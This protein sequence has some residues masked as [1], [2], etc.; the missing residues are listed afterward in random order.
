LPVLVL[1]FVAT[2]VAVVLIVAAVVGLAP[3]RTVAVGPGFDGRILVGLPSGGG[4]T[5]HL[6]GDGAEVDGGPLTHV[7]RARCPVLL[8]TADGIAVR[9]RWKGIRFESF[10]G[11]IGS[12]WYSTMYNGGERWSTDLSTLAMIDFDRGPSVITF[13]DGDLERP[14]V[15]AYAVPGSFE[16]ILSTDGA[17]L[18]LA[19]PDG[20]GSL[21]IHVLEEGVDTVVATV[22]SL[23][24]D[25][26]VSGS[27]SVDG[28]SLL[29]FTFDANG[30]RLFVVHPADGSV[31]RL[32]RPEGLAPSATLVPLGWSGNG[33]EMLTYAVVGS[34]T[35]AAW[36]L[37]W[38]G[39][40][41]PLETSLAP[42]ETSLGPSE[43]SLRWSPDGELGVITGST[44][45][46]HS[47]DG[48]VVRSVPLPGAVSTW[49]P[50]GTAIAT[51]AN[52]IGSPVEVWMTDA[53]GSGASMRVASIE[54]SHPVD[55]SNPEM[56]CIQW[57]PEVTP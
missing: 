5:T 41:Y 45:R 42:S 32:S 15:T 27:W 57:Q 52:T 38:R 31:R 22:P 51:L 30:Q 10:E 26:Y 18:A 46:I 39:D 2:A 7:D 16:G 48:H 13:P 1:I 8:R 9:D 37:D 17:R 49:S 47:S 36:V 43:A 44:L 55:H 12:P 21:A 40:W 24:G 56:T 14:T 23:G 4:V 11:D 34:E 35:G 25:G 6:L 53:W 50:D 3:D 54:P 33:V 19:V 20:R 29:L 28:R